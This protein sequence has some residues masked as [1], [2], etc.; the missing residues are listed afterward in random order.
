LVNAADKSS[1]EA[2]RKPTQGG[3]ITLENGWCHPDG[4]GLG[5]YPARWQQ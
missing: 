3:W 2:I 5:H 1:L 4:A